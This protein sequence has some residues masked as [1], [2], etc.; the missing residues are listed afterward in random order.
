MYVTYL[1][2]YFINSA[3]FNFE[4]IFGPIKLVEPPPLLL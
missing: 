2:V 3:S 4:G 1:T